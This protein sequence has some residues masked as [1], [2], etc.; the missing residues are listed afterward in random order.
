MSDQ[1][2][3]LEQEEEVKHV[4]LSVSNIDTETSAS[5]PFSQVF[6]DDDMEMNKTPGDQARSAFYYMI[7]EG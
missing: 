6:V 4:E 5:T 7:T 1:I 3:A 2:D